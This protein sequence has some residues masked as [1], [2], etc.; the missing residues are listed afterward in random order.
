MTSEDTV[1]AHAWQ[2]NP[3]EP[4]RTVLLHCRQSVKRTDAIWQACTAEL[5]GDFQGAAHL[6]LMQLEQELQLDGLSVAT[7]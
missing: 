7:G 2:A 4:S 6:E 5:H 1:M 3:C